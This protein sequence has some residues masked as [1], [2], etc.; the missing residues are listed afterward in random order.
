MNN[1]IQ[2]YTTY[3]P[4]GVEWLGDIPEHWEVKKLRHVRKCQNG[5]SKGGEYFGSG[6]PFVSYSDVYKILSYPKLSV[7]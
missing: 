6:Y 7:V 1:N 2:K 3:K 5:I 4:S